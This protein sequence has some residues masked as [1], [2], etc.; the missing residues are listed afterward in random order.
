MSFSLVVL[1]IVA[2]L[3]IAYLLAPSIRERM[4][5]SPVQTVGT[6]RRGM[7][8][9]AHHDNRRATYMASP[10]VSG[11]RP[12][13][14]PTE[15]AAQLVLHEPK[16]RAAAQ[17]RQSIMVALSGATILF[18]LLGLFSHQLWW[19]AFPLLVL[20]LAYMSLAHEAARKDEARLRAEKLDRI[21]NQR[22]R[23]RLAQ[24]DVTMQPL[25]VGQTDRRPPSRLLQSPRHAQPQ[26]NGPSEGRRHARREQRVPRGV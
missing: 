19:V 12:V 25:P 2:I 16:R 8:A 23:V 1:A 26:R 4:G 7:N 18:F 21:R 5:A 10:T 22:S 17:R 15:P 11:T 9:L 13:L 20:T 14:V 24:G 6:F 3:F